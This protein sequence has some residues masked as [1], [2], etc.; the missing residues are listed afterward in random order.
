MQIRRLARSSALSAA[1]AAILLA[2]CSGGGDGG[3]DSAR[4]GTLKLGITDAPVDFAEDVVVKFTAVELKPKEGPS[5]T[6]PIAEGSVDLLDY[7]GTDRM[8][9]LDGVEV[10]AGEYV[11][12]RL[13]VAADPNV[14]GD[15]YLR[16]EQ[17]GAE[18]ELRIPSGDET[19]LKLNR[20]FTVGVGSITDFTIDFDLRKSVIAPPGQT[21]PVDTCGGQAY[22]LKPVLRVVDN[23][24]VGSIT[25]A[26]DPALIQAQ[27]ESST[28]APY[29]GNVY[30]YG[31]VT[32]AT[33]A[34]DDYDGVPN[35]P[36]G[37]D[38]LT[39]AMVDP[40]T[41]R[42]TIGYVP[43][44]SYE[45]AYTCDVDSTTVDADVVPTPPETGEVVEFTPADG[46]AV[47]VTAG[48]ATVQDFTL[49][50]P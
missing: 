17:G 3:G 20:G 48:Q 49:P 11:W 31:P 44:G 14:V 24:Q 34:P 7:Q 9:L 5:I 38:P 4:T 1:V 13:A 18:C 30:L 41:F 29:P 12:M 16:L 39:S 25:G 42:Y 32:A 19:G 43:V 22:T 47:S 33:V 10:P 28:E 37:D 35:D 8:M 36:N 27:C 15:S 45:L 21:T 2:G 40:A 46:I 23:L 26:V 50:A 6:I